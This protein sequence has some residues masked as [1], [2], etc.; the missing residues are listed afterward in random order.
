ME[1]VRDLRLLCVFYRHL[2]ETSPHIVSGRLDIEDL[3]EYDSET[4]L[5]F[6]SLKVG[7]EFIAPVKWEP[8]RCRVTHIYKDTFFYE[9][10]E[11]SRKGTEDSAD[12]TSPFTRRHYWPC[13]IL[14]FKDCGVS[15]SEH[16]KTEVC[17]MNYDQSI[18]EELIK[19]MIHEIPD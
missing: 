4:M 16:Y 14:L 18:A 5:D 12:M 9:V 7:D 2:I 1:T 11:G 19:K 13:R 6:K 15:V 17:Y 3:L 10:L 8:Q